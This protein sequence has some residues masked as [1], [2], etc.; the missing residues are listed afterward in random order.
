M[1]FLGF[2]SCKAD[3]D[4]WMREKKRND[5]SIYWEH[6]PLLYVDDCLCISEDPESI[7]WNEIG[8]YFKV[9]EASIGEPDIYLGGKVQKI[10]LETGVE[11]WAFSSSQYVQ[12]ACRNV[13]QCLEQ[14]Y[15]EK[16]YHKTFQILKKAGAPISTDYR[17]EI[18]ISTELDAADASYY[19]S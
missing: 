1:K 2:T 19:Q 12:E 8:K 11:C 17:L 18:D 5:G 15:K 9:K 14:R 10:E 3:A 6:V 4:V 7:I 16:N 13:R